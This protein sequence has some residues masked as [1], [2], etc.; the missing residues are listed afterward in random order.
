M[1]SQ[2]V[3]EKLQTQLTSVQE[4]SKRKITELK[5]GPSPSFIMDFIV[6][7]SY[8]QH[9]RLIKALRSILQTHSRFHSF[10]RKFFIMITMHF[11][12]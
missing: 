6:F 5:E 10:P 3:N 11:P 12:R 4:D 9:M 2:A 1:T 7:I 8:S